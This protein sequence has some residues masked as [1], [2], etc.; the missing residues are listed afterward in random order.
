MIYAIGDIHGQAEMLATALNYLI[1]NLLAP[2]D[3]VV[4][5]GDYVD[6]G[7]DSRGVF[8]LLHQ[9]RAHHGEERVVF[10]RGNHE[11]MLLTARFDPEEESLWLF[12]GGWETLASYGIIH[13]PE[14]FSQL[15]EADRDLIAGTLL[16]YPAGRYHFVHAG[17]PPHDAPEMPRE[18]RLW[19]RDEFIESEQDF[20]AIVVFG[21]TIIPTLQ[22][23]VMANKIGID[24]GAFLPD[25]KLTMAAFDPEEEID[26]VPEFTYYQVNHHGKIEA[27]RLR[28]AKPK[29]SLRRKPKPEAAAAS[30]DE[31]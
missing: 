30:E 29:R 2:E 11:D 24:T 6:R 13:S 26:G 3:T 27:F 31:S 17:I 19:I 4:F 7:P 1:Q 14:W 12:N 20:G 28:K 9:F 10:L 5:M 22:P 16:E 25:G 18:P 21:H 8:E 15:P 23:L